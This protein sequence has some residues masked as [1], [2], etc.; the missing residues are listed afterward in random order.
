MTFSTKSTLSGSPYF[1]ALFNHNIVCFYA[2]VQA[3]ILST[4]YIVTDPLS[5]GN[6][7]VTVSQCQSRVLFLTFKLVC[8]WP[9]RVFQK[10]YIMPVSTSS[11]RESVDSLCRDGADARIT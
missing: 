6:S 1:I 3:V 2:S 4:V 11:I 7:T 9:K 5:Q 10:F 8:Y